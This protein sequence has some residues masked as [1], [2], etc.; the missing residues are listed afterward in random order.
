MSDDNEFQSRQ[1]R[2]ERIKN[3][4][5]QIEEEQKVADARKAKENARRDRNK[6]AEAK[7]QQE[8]IENSNKQKAAVEEAKAKKREQQQE[9]REMMEQKRQSKKLQNNVSVDK[10]S[11][12]E[13]IQAS[14]ISASASNLAKE[15]VSTELY[16][17]GKQVSEKS[18]PKNLVKIIRSEQGKAI[19]ETENEIKQ[20]TPSVEGNHTPSSNNLEN[21]RF[22]S[23]NYSSTLRNGSPVIPGLDINM[24]NSNPTNMMSGNYNLS[25]GSRAK[26]NTNP[27]TSDRNF[28]D[29]NNNEENPNEEDRN[30]IPTDNSNN[31]ASENNS[32]TNNRDALRA[33]LAGLNSGSNINDKRDVKDTNS[34]GLNSNDNISN[35]R[36]FENEK[37]F[38]PNNKKD[39]LGATPGMMTGRSV[40][41]R[42]GTTAGMPMADGRDIDSEMSNR[43]A[44]NMGRA[45]R[46]AGGAT[47]KI[48]NAKKTIKAAMKA[49]KM[50]TIGS[51]LALGG[52]I[53]VVIILVVGAIS[54]VMNMPGM[55]RD[56]I[57]NTW[58]TFWQ[59]AKG[60][61]SELLNGPKEPSPTV[62]KNLAEYLESMGYDLVD[63][64]FA[65]KLEK[66]E[67]GNIKDIESKYLLAYISAEERSYLIA[68]ENYSVASIWE[69]V[70]GIF[71]KDDITNANWGTGMIV[72][73]RN[74]IEEVLDGLAPPELMASIASL[75][76]SIANFF[77]GKSESEDTQVRNISSITTRIFIKRDTKEMFISKVDIID[78]F[79]T[80]GYDVYRYSL[81]EW[82][83]KYGTPTELFLTLHL[84]TRAPEFAYKFAT[85]YDTKVF[86]EIMELKN[87]DVSLVYAKTDENNKIVLDAN[88]KPEMIPISQ[89]DDA[90][91]KSKGISQSALEEMRKINNTKIT[92]FTPYITKVLNHWYYQQVIF[93]G[94]YNGK[95]IDVYEIRNLKETD[96]GYVRYYAYTRRDNA[97]Q[98][99]ID[100]DARD[101][102]PVQDS[103]LWGLFNIALEAMKIAF[104]GGFSGISGFMQTASEAALNEAYN[105]LSE[106]VVNEISAQIKDLL[107]DQLANMLNVEEFLKGNLTLENLRE[108]AEN[109]INIDNMANLVDFDKIAQQLDIDNLQLNVENLWDELNLEDTLLNMD[110]A[111]LGSINDLEKVVNKLDVDNLEKVFDEQFDKFADF[112]DVNFDKL[113]NRLVNGFSSSIEELQDSIVKSCDTI[114]SG[115][116][117]ADFTKISDN[118]LNGVT[119]KLTDDTLAPIVN[120][121]NTSIENIVSG[122]FNTEILS[123]LQNEF[124]KQLTGLSYSDLNKL[125]SIPG[126]DFN[127][128]KNLSGQVTGITSA[129]NGAENSINNL[130]NQVNKLSKD[131]TGMDT[132]VLGAVSNSVKEIDNKIKLVEDEITATQELINALN[133][134]KTETKE[135]ENK[136]K[137]LKN[138]TLELKNA[139][140][141]LELEEIN[142]LQ[143]EINTCKADIT[144]ITN[145]IQ[146]LDDNTIGRIKTQITS[147]ENKATGVIDH[148][149]SLDEINL[150]TLTNRL[151]TLDKTGLIELADSF[152]NLD[153]ASNK[154]KTLV[155]QYASD[156]SGLRTSDI[157]MIINGINGQN[158]S[159]QQAI[160]S[161]SRYLMNSDQAE[162]INNL[163]TLDNSIK[164]V[165]NL[166]NDFDINT[167]A[168]L[169]NKVPGLDSL[170][171]NNIANQIK[172]LQNT[173]V[174][175][176]LKKVEELPKQLVNDV[177]K[178]LTDKLKQGVKDG[179]SANLSQKLKGSLTSSGNFTTNLKDAMT[180]G[181]S[182]NIDVEAEE[183]D[184]EASHAEYSTGFYVR[185]IRTQDYF[186]KA[187]PVRVL[188]SPSHWVKMFREDK[189]IILDTP[190][191][192]MSKITDPEYVEQ[193]GKTIWEAT[194]GN[195]QTS[196]Y[197]MLQGIQSADSQYLFRYFKEL[198]NDVSWAFDANFGFSPPIDPNAINP[199][200][201][202]WIFKTAK[203][204]EPVFIGEAK[205]HSVKKLKI[206]AK[207]VENINKI[208]M[209]NMPE[210]ASY[211]TEKHTAP[212]L[213]VVSEI[214]V[215]PV[216]NK[217]SD[218]EYAKQNM[219]ANAI[220]YQIVP[221]PDVSE[222]IDVDYRYIGVRYYGYKDGNKFDLE[223]TY[224]AYQNAEL[225]E[226]EKAEYE[227]YTWAASK[228]GILNSKALDPVYGFDA[229]LDIVSPVN[230]V[231]VAKTEARKNELGQ[232]VAQSV[233]IELRDTGDAN[234]DGMR[235][236]LIGGDYSSL[237]V[238]SLVRKVE[239]TV[240]EDGNYSEGTSGSVI[241]KT[242]DEAIKIMVLDKDQTPVDDVSKYI[243]P[244]Y[245]QYKPLK[246]DES[247]EQKQ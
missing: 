13:Q 72:L 169:V 140:D 209:D 21:N 81:K 162:L 182:E 143:N 47:K 69:G 54:F 45:G 237:M 108:L 247:N 62:I 205:V 76:E 88:G 11:T 240:D 184:V 159:T 244:P 213:E 124:A 198:F 138:K 39:S 220:S 8:R 19:R 178:K 46:L 212:K 99:K 51:L 241:G 82:T 131:V 104:T 34:K 16:E 61:V 180:S 154:M 136:L 5:Y 171:L 70:K 107:P 139:S 191:V 89:M 67:E 90:T 177:S 36:D 152:S 194:D 221:G 200:T 210:G 115:V 68:N 22:L 97:D 44:T 202:G 27:N 165:T 59:E 113:T 224:Y 103:G 223:I 190:G 112:T 236:I 57:A 176:L 145:T 38:N 87:V 77:M 148:I 158:I 80:G 95:K 215:K 164:L 167:V 6:K 231:V 195:I 185:E 232:N 147:L 137:E 142:K 48:L 79:N 126:M 206:D 101:D 161:V 41:A 203:V 130:S 55:V 111:G 175:Q 129:L 3:I 75:T 192:D 10:T 23:N 18:L 174:D 128:L 186:Q 20:A 160:N 211:Y 98:G 30:D 106:A 35:M 105:M 4:E 245:Q 43:I 214:E 227:P 235:I 179:I 242:T 117:E 73:E 60:T 118:L 168:N 123:G 225:Q 204:K 74:A 193:Y 150:T 183:G 63:N 31:D 78:A 134:K 29:A 199:D 15:N 14:S 121:L 116:S 181:P 66:D 7:K 64:G 157:N 86:L 91:I 233:T 170:H 207:D 188:Y 218:E 132:K 173:T 239:Y 133:S 120:N 141:K 228:V 109:G 100:D 153:V 40:G 119:K 83:E 50:L 114:F 84:A 208:A 219:P 125:A 127:Q 234:A 246:G 230:G 12:G 92:A 56:K 93:Q 149:T 226:V 33:N 187:E 238:G 85:T 25:T 189:Y 172:N 94:E 229:G 122:K 17:N 24:K 144:R 156:I 71:G 2:N 26:N 42:R 1:E 37:G 243:Y 163:K 216:D 52:I 28:D 110:I 146:G 197:A 217:I 166:T 155:T 135:L 53:I 58:D 196:I 102:P 32:N 201:I 222:D 65:T 49:K 96:P 9:A 151:R